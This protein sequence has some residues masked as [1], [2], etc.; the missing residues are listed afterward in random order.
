[1]L[2]MWIVELYLS[3]LTQLKYQQSSTSQSTNRA[4]ELRQ[5]LREFLD[6][7][8]VKVESFYLGFLIRFFNFKLYTWLACVC[9]LCAEMLR[10]TERPR[11]R[12]AR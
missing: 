1:M 10:A 9:V 11:V 7:P 3:Q 8:K 12:V 2:V 6:D 4:A 5:S